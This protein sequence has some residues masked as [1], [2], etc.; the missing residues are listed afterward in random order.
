[1]VSLQRE[2]C[3]KEKTVYCMERFEGCVWSFQVLLESKGEER[4]EPLWRSLDPPLWTP[5]MLQLDM[6]RV[7]PIQSEEVWESRSICITLQPLKPRVESLDGLPLSSSHSIPNSG[8]ICH[9]N[10][11]FRI[12]HERKHT[13]I[14]LLMQ[15]SLFTH[16]SA[17]K[18]SLLHR[19]YSLNPLFCV[20]SLLFFKVSSVLVFT[21]VF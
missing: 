13:Q 19:I 1:M 4:N 15:T 7:W 2:R 21:L 14:C 9:P 6:L 11:S 10:P 5:L 17:L 12:M 3:G 18:C 16:S 8:R 20:D